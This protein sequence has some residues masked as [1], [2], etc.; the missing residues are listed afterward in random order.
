M[1]L[2]EKKT[3]KHEYTAH[4]TKNLTTALLLQIVGLLKF[5]LKIVSLKEGKFKLPNLTPTNNPC[6]FPSQTKINK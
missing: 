3:A 1:T 6:K 2:S 5:K 4:I